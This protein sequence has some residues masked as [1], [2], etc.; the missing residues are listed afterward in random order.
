MRFRAWVVTAVGAFAVA[1]AGPALAGFAGSDVFLPMVGRQAG[2]HPSN[3]YTTVW[4]HNPGGE[5]ATARIYFLERGTANPTPPFV[6]VLVAPGGTEKLDNIVE[7]YFHEQAFGALRVT[8]ATQRL[9]V[10]SRVYSKAIGEGENDSVGQD[11]AGVP[12]AFAIGL[13]ER[14]Q[15]LGAYQTQPAAG[16]E[17]RFTFGVVETTGH[18]ATVRVRALDASGAEQGVTSF[19]V[20]EWS[21]RQVAFKDHFPLVSTENG[22]L[23]VEVI[24][25]TG[26]VIAY[27][28]GIAN[29]S[30]DP[31]TFEMVYS[32][33]LLGISTVAHD[34]TLTGDGSAAAPLGIADD[35]VGTEQLADGAV[36]DQKVASG[37]AYAKRSG[38]PAALPPNG[39]A[40]GVL[41]GTYPAPGLASDAVGTDQLAAAAVTP[42]KISSAGASHGQVLKYGSSIDWRDDALTLPYQESIASAGTAFMVTN[43]AGSAVVAVSGS[44]V[45]V[46]GIGGGDL[47]TPLLTPIGVFGKSQTGT[48]VLGLAVASP[49]V[50]GHSTSANGVGGSSVESFGVRGTAGS[51]VST[52]LPTSRAGVLGSS[53][54]SVG[55]LGVS[56]STT[57]VLGVSGDSTGVKGESYDGTGVYGVSH[58]GYGVRGEGTFAGVFGSSTDGWGVRGVTESG[59]EYA[60]QFFNETAGGPGVYASAGS[61]GAP[62]LVLGANSS[63][64]D[65]GL[66]YSSQSYSGSDIGL[67]SMDKVW[68]DLDDDNN[69]GGSF[70][71]VRSGSDDT[72]FLVQEDG[73]VQIPKLGTGST[74]AVYATASGFLTLTAPPSDA[75]LKANVVPLADE[76]DVLAGL[77]RLTGVRFNWDTSQ[78]RAREL[79]PQREVGLIAQDVETVIPELVTYDAQGYRSIDYSRLSAFLVEVAKAQ[80]QRIERQE[81]AILDLLARVRVIERTA[82]RGGKR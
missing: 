33:E 57:A 70:F 45:G 50:T 14:S 29:A 72:I 13:G 55:V 62:D 78:P 65:D 32:D 10:T 47:S 61:D 12:V 54:N 36:T 48:G 39:A 18:A 28:S 40:G 53:G 25:G 44:L 27:G 63:G 8:C 24:A 67:Q 52:G 66:I 2:V 19:Q 5:A 59:S 42:D 37:I 49:G 68:I 77:D 51:P 1:A 76:I 46:T 80:Q 30:Q 58:E 56:D 31:T 23:E 79:G 21:Q 17:Y 73:D 41:T 9:V 60:G 20:R 11:F 69:S 4:V 81:K 16:S 43:T 3:W 26:K 15:I 38:A 75:R 35:G 7:A 22:R 6:D 64:S 74:K 71:Q 82:E 34:S